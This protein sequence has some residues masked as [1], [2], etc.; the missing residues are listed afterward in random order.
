MLS[1]VR[2][3]GYEIVAYVL[4]VVELS[5]P[6]RKIVLKPGEVQWKFLSLS[7]SSA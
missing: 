3:P 5:K 1:L 4:R 7:L 6:Y 2:S